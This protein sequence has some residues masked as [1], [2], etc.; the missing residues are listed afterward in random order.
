MAVHNPHGAH[1]NLM[2]GQERLAGK[3][4]LSLALS[5]S[6]RYCRLEKAAGWSQAGGKAGPDNA[7]P[8]KLMILTCTNGH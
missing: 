7:L 8:P 6:V 5:D 3:V 2:V 1:M 4:P